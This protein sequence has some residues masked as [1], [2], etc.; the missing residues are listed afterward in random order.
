VALN[1]K[2]EKMSFS[3]IDIQRIKNEVGGLCKRKTPVHLKDKLRFDY[4]IEKQNV[5]IYEIR[6]VWNN[7]AEFTSL[8]IAKLTYVAIRKIWK[9]YWKRASGK[10]V[11]YET[12]TSAKDLRALVQAI[13]EDIYGCFFG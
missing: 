1:E 13:E 7:P 10:W 2:D 6:P 3:D 12:E 9:L 11:R 8:P 5:I 4:A